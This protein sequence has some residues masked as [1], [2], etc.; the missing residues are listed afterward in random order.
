MSTFKENIETEKPSFGKLIFDFFKG[1][2]N[3]SDQVDK[4]RTREEV[5]AN[6]SFKGMPAFILMASVFVASIG[7]NAN[8]VAVVIG[9]MLISPL[10][11]PIMG[12]GYSVAVNDIDTLKKS[13]TNFFIMVGIALI[14]SYLYFLFVPLKTLNEQLIGR[15]EPTSLDVLIGISGGLAGIAAFSSKIKNSNVIAGVAIAT[16]L[17]PPLCTAGYGFAMGSDL[18]GYKDYTGIGAGL[19]ALYLFFIN[20]VFIGIS[21]FL[22]IKLNKFPLAKY[23][24]AAQA[25][26]T[27]FIIIILSVITMLPSAFI[28]YDIIKEEFYKAKVK[29]FLREEVSPMYQ[30]G[31]L[32]INNPILSDRD[33]LRF[34]TISTLTERVPEEVIK[35]WNK[36]L[37]SKYHLQNTKLIVHQGGY[38]EDF[39]R[40]KSQDFMGSIYLN[41]QKE[42]RKK[43]SIILELQ[44]QIQRLNSDSIPFISVAKELRAQYPNIKNFGY[45]NFSKTNFKSKNI[46]PTFLIQWDNSNKA[47]AQREKNEDE[48]RIRS[49][50]RTRLSLD[51]L[52][53]VQ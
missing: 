25:R 5:L 11:G 4:T 36:V 48:K 47:K 9:A 51:T 16:A 20:S 6:I 46:I 24:N 33:S 32:N 1:I 30:N 53:I 45:A 39:L 10:M 19:N 8:S 43:D 35:N 34:I 27:N 17:M 50:L 52:D 3:L 12:L 49:Y 38:S 21:T 28:F 18:I 41:N 15:I 26:K 7:L 2:F 37:K 31:F 22:Y 23:Q 29:E 40:Q 42:I 14:T 13:L 44:H